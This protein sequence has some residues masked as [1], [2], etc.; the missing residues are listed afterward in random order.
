MDEQTEKSKSCE[1]ARK[2][3]TLVLEAEKAFTIGRAS[4]ADAA[5]KQLE[6]VNKF[7]PRAAALVKAYCR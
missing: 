1:M 3:Q 2:E 7:K 4:N 6:T 5:N